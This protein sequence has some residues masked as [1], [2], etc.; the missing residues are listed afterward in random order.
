MR[1]FLSALLSLVVVLASCGF[2]TS[3]SR[4]TADQLYTEGKI[5]KEEHDRLTEGSWSNLLAQLGIVGVGM[6]TTYLGIQR[7]RG[8]VASSNE[9]EHRMLAL[10][11]QRQKLAAAKA[12]K[13]RSASPAPRS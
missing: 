4:S 1:Y 12:A 2:M 13:A 5:T 3:S 7:S 6:A 9:R 11:D 8:P 10:S